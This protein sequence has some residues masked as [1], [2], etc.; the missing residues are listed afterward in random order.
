V[1]NVYLSAYVR[2]RVE[3][4]NERAEAKQAEARARRAG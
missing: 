4:R 3:I 2:L 1:A